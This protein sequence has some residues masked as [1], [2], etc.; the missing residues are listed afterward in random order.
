MSHEIRTP[1]TGVLGM[2]DLLMDADLPA[3]ERD[4]V[5]G[6][7][8]SGRHLL[9]LIND[10][11][12]FS[13]I[14]AGK[15]DL[16]IID[17]RLPRCW[18]R[19]AR[20]WRRRRPNA[21]WSCALNSTHSPPRGQGRSDPAEAGAGQ[22]GWQR[23]EIHPSGQRNGRRQPRR[24]TDRERFRFEVRDTGIGIPE[25]KRDAVRRFQSGGFLDHTQIWRQRARLGDLQGICRCDGRRDRGR[26]PGRRR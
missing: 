8:A 17:F 16:E 21:A 5:M 20:C 26:E 4:Y 15:L 23:T 6:I 19:C 24:R 13:R 9:A 7:R 18:S 25:E 12:D 1:M 2:A 3:K 10:I 22:F 11:L 14:E